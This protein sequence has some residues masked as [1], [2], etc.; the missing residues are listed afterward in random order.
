MNLT[1]SISM[2]LIHI[3]LKYE[4]C[5]SYITHTWVYL[6][7][8]GWVNS[9]MTPTRCQ[10]SGVRS[11][12]S[13]SWTNSFDISN[14]FCMRNQW[15]CHIKYEIF[16]YIF[17]EFIF[18]YK[19]IIFIL[20]YLSFHGI[21]LHLINILYSFLIWINGRKFIPCVNFYIFSGFLLKL[22]NTNSLKNPIYSHTR[23]I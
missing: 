5:S 23:Q 9:Q 8:I 15:K 21:H 18:K 7:L 11:N 19:I 2:L 4:P 17:M 22:A 20:K 3:V 14:N 13:L 16:H 1:P 12:P 6:M 10:M